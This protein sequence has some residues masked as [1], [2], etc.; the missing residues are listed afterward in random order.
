MNVFDIMMDIKGKTKDSNKARLDLAA[1][2]N[3]K[4]LELKDIIRGKNQRKYMHLPNPKESLFVNGL[5]NLSCQMDV[6]PIWVDVLNLMTESYMEWKVMIVMF[7][8]NDYF[9]LHLTLY[10]NQFGKF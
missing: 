8:C 4:E 2:R 5:K 9:Q 1:I 10:Q 6:L 7:S 3:W